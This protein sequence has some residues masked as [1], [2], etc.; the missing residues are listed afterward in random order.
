M[1]NFYTNITLRGPGQDEVAAVLSREGREALV[2]P[3]VNGFTT[4]FDAECEMQD[5]RVLAALAADLSSEFACPALA[6]LNHDDDVFLYELY[7]NGELMDTYDSAPGYFDSSTEPSAPKGGNAEEL[8][9]AMGAPER[10]AEVRSILRKSGFADEGYVF[11]F[12]R[13]KA[14]GD[15]LGLPSLSVAAGYTYLCQ[16]ELPEGV[17]PDDFKRTG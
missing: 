9:S 5:T 2:S 17:S 8:C 13:H 11:E 7:S 4:V 3:T 1:G 12:E 6:V 14:L 10:A 15:A 16:G